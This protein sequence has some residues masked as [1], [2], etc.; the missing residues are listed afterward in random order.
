MIDYNTLFHG[1]RFELTSKGKLDYKIT[2]NKMLVLK[3]ILRNS[4]KIDLFVDLKKGKVFK[5]II[6]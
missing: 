1:Y 3:Q 6:N 5:K 4:Q 2:K